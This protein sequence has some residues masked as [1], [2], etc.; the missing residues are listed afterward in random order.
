MVGFKK[1]GDA[2]HFID[3]RPRQIDIF[4][5]Y[6]GLLGFL[7]NSS[8]TT[9]LQP[10]WHKAHCAHRLNT[11]QYVDFV[12]TRHGLCLNGA[13]DH[14]NRPTCDSCDAC[15]PATSKSAFNCGRMGYRSNSIFVP[16]FILNPARKSFCKL[17]IPAS[18]SKG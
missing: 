11:A 13:S 5:G 6:L 3:E 2:D 1:G 12:G 16:A 9:R 4:V 10:R 8:C 14:S 18:A 17:D 7:F 15:K